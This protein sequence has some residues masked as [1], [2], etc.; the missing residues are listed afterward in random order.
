V[1]KFFI[2]LSIML[3]VLVHL[4]YQTIRECE[5]KGGTMFRNSCIEVKKVK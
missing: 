3:V 4:H 1:L 5:L 2:I